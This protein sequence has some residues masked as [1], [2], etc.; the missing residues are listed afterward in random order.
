M[1]FT[2][3]AATN[4]SEPRAATAGATPWSTWWSPSVSRA[5]TRPMAVAPGR[6]TTTGAPTAGHARTRRAAALAPRAASSAQW[7]RS[8]TTSPPRTAGRVPQRSGPASPSACASTT[9]STS[10]VLTAPPAIQAPLA[11]SHAC[12]C[13]FLL[14]VTRER[15]G[16]VI[17]VLRVHPH[18]AVTTSSTIVGA[19]RLPS[20]ASQC[21]LVFSHYGG[22]SDGASC[23]RYYPEFGVPSSLHRSLKWAAKS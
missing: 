22:G 2:R 8:W 10:F 1:W 20:L 12:S 9:A 17:S 15:L 23:R 14:N 19:D 11:A 7:P 5:R 16:H 18:A 3:P 21:E 4:W 13:L 6:H